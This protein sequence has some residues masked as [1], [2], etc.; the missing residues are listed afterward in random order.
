MLYSSVVCLVVWLPSCRADKAPADFFDE[1]LEDDKEFFD[2]V[3]AM[4][5]GQN[6]RSMSML[7]VSLQLVFASLA[8]KHIIIL[9]YLIK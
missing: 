8:T 4:K 9:F 6:L 7:N 5:D 1:G 3:T 2:I